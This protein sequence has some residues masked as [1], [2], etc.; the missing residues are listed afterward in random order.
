M[1]CGGGGNEDAKGLN[2]IREVL[3]G[4]L[5]NLQIKFA[6]K[7]MSKLSTILN[8]A[9]TGSEEEWRYA[10][11]HLAAG[12]MLLQY[13]MFNRGE[14]GLKDLDKDD[15]AQF[16]LGLL[17]VLAHHIFTE[18]VNGDGSDISR[19]LDQPSTKIVL[20]LAQQLS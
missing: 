3:V 2:P 15:L 13:C 19:Q 14:N 9:S 1:S 7:Y 4:L 17:Y 20:Q 12:M 10:N 16:V 8:Q 18:N 6:P 11:H 5:N